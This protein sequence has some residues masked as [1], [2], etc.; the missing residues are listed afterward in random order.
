MSNLLYPISLIQ[1]LRV[2]Q[3]DRVI[4]DAFEDGNT[5]ARRA[6]LA[7]YFKRRFEIQHAPL[8]QT[9]FNYLRD[10]WE[11][12]GQ[13]DS[14]YFRDNVNREGNFNVRFSGALLKEFQGRGRP[15]VLTLDEVKASG[16]NVAA[17]AALTGATPIVWWD[18]HLEH[19]YQHT[20]TTYYTST[21]NVADHLASY[22]SPWQAGTPALI[23]P[24]GEGYK[25]DGTLWAKTSANISQ[26]VGSSPDLTLFMIARASATT[27]IQHFV[28]IGDGGFGGFGLGL[29]NHGSWYPIRANTVDFVGDPGM[30]NTPDTWTSVAL[31]G[32]SSPA[33]YVNGVAG[34]S[35]ASLNYSLGAGP[36]VFGGVNGGV[37]LANPGNAMTNANVG[38]ALLFSSKLTAAQ[39]R[40]LHNL[41][42]P[43]YGMT[44][45]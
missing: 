15:I 16:V 4:V 24:L 13:Y 41:L 35:I 28:S 34:G 32:W 38:H 29:T 30:A 8:T 42:G 27:T 45:V 2:T 23:S 22:T 25:F 37:R 17:V 40:A 26:L 44:R 5:A 9:E 11:A 14:F 10:F 21:T 36:M 1:R 19:Y 6:W 33:F 18:A 43:A 31:A 7:G 12:R 3:L 39:I 20:G